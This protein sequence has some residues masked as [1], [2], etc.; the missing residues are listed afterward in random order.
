MY[1]PDKLVGCQSWQ[2]AS[3]YASDKPVVFGDLPDDMFEEI[4]KSFNG[5]Q[6]RCMACVSWKFNKLFGFGWHRWQYLSRMGIIAERVPVYE[7]FSNYA[8]YMQSHVLLFIQ[9]Q[10][11]LRPVMY[12][13]RTGMV[14]T[15]DQVPSIPADRFSTR[16]TDVQFSA[17]STGWR[18]V[19]A[20]SHR[21]HYLD[22][23]TGANEWTTVQI[24]DLRPGSARPLQLR[25]SPSTIVAYSRYANDTYAA[26]REAMEF[27][28][29]VLPAEVRYCTLVQTDSCQVNPGLFLYTLGQDLCLFD[30]T[31]NR[32]VVNNI[33]RRS[34]SVYFFTLDITAC[35]VN[36]ALYLFEYV[37][38]KMVRYSFIERKWYRCTYLQRE[39]HGALPLVVGKFIYLFGGSET[40]KRSMLLPQRV[41]PSNAVDRYDTDTDTWE[42]LQDTPYGLGSVVCAVQY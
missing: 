31:S 12:N 14:S 1:Y 34:L 18:V 22:A 29:C 39:R 30:E 32:F 6:F 38:F 24:T 10:G 4:G 20:D 40:D 8:P 27:R 26:D 11:G 5:E 33:F 15:T 13:T 7:P 41:I 19:V 35:M 36:G 23:H 2:W 42:V 37:P 16:I 3:V 28:P 21:V 25:C 17:V 9:E